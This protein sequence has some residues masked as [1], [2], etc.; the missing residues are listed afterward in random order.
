MPTRP[1]SH[2]PRRIDA[3]RHSAYDRITRR[4]NPDT[5]VA[6]KI[7]S[8]QAWKNCRRSHLSFHPLCANPFGLHSPHVLA[9]D[10]HHLTEIGLRPDLAFDPDNLQSVCKRCHA[11]HSAR[12]R[13]LSR[14]K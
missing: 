10:V 3:P 8:S 14:R 2:R 13:A 7:R 11:K 5:A 6:F 4:Q 1:P 9:A 12:E